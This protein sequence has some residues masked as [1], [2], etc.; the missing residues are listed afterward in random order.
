LF[1][2]Q[3][4]EKGEGWRGR[5]PISPSRTHPPMTYDLS[6]G[7]SAYKFPP[8]LNNTK[9]RTKSLAHN[10]LGNVPDPNY[11]R[12]QVSLHISL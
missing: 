9:L 3:D 7:S 12:E 5:V 10:P 11:S 6:V 2:S 4:V 8:L 1:H